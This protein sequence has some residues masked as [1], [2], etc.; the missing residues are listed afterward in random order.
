MEGTKNGEVEPDRKQTRYKYSAAHQ[1]VAVCCNPN[2]GRITPYFIEKAWLKEADNI[3]VNVLLM[4]NTIE[5]KINNQTVKIETI[6][7]YPYQNKFTFKISNPKKVAFKIKIR[8]PSWAIAVVA[9]EKYSEE[10]EFLIFNRNFSNQD[11]I[12]LEFKAAIL[13]KEDKKQDKYF[14]YGALFYAKTIAAI[15]KKGK[16]YGPNFVDFLYQ[17]MNEIRYQYIEDHKAV[18]K[19]GQLHLNAKNMN[20]DQLEEIILIPFGKTILRQVSF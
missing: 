4:P 18:F 16:Y 5:T 11:S 12:T 8:K 6:T 9:S 19:N 7:D 2:A 14:T 13:I 20:T 17:P 3:L 15:E 10:N 1:D